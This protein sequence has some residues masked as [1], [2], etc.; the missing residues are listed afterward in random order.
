MGALEITKPL[1]SLGLIISGVYFF[2]EIFLFNYKTP[3]A[4]TLRVFIAILFV[5]LA[6]FIF[7]YKPLE[8]DKL[9][10]KTAPCPA[11]YRKVP[12]NAERCPHCG[13]EFSTKM[14]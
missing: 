8:R 12:I 11:C 14:V 10:I 2:S 4:I 5:N 7:M 1:L 9:D 13:K 3:L 6:I